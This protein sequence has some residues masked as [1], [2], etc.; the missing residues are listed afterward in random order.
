[1]GKAVERIRRAQ[2]LYYDVQSQSGRVDVST[3][4]EWVP[5]SLE[6]RCVRPGPDRLPADPK[7]ASSHQYQR[8]LSGD[9]KCER[10]S[11]QR[12]ELAARGVSYL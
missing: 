4:R 7:L 11:F 6:R 3:Y 10:P 12:Q 8:H 1:M 2:L 5:C 9:R